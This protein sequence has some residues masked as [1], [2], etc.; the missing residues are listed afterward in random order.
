MLAHPGDGPKPAFARGIGTR[1]TSDNFVPI[2][3][4]TPLGP[5][6]KPAK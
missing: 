2:M 4:I 5:A 1:F 6:R 3:D